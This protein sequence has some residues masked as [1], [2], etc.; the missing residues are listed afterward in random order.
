MLTQLSTVKAR[1]SI[2]DPASDDLLN[3]VIATYSE[4]FDRECNRRFARQVDATE[5]FSAD[6]LEICPANW[7]IETVASFALKSN[8]SDGW[9]PLS[10]QP[11][12]LLRNGCVISLN[13]ALG[14]RYQQAQVTFSGGYVL[15][16][17]TPTAGQT[18]LPPDIEQACVEQVVYWFQNRSTVGLVT[19]TATAGTRMTQV[20]LLA[21]VVEV[22]KKYTRMSFD[23]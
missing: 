19:A 16:G 13:Y 21:N 15:P 17:T 12:C 14:S 11:D 9:Q 7:P 8:E 5:E 18:A 20:D 10:P 1:L 4:R 2:T 6:Q 23:Q 22:L 3:N